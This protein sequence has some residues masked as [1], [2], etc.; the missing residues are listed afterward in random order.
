MNV[1]HALMDITL[2]VLLN[3]PN[4]SETVQRV[5]ELVLQLA[6]NAKEVTYWIYKQ[7]LHPTAQFYVELLLLL[8][9]GVKRLM[10]I[11]L[12]IHKHVRLVIFQMQLIKHVLNAATTVLSVLQL[13]NVLLIS[14]LMVTLKMQLQ[15]LRR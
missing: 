8:G 6:L 7:L 15:I 4:V 11:L 9:I 2:M 13:M 10:L 3:A 14:V 5:L 12:F 1:Q